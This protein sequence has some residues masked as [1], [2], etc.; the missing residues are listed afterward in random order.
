MGRGASLLYLS[1]AWRRPKFADDTKMW[2]R[3]KPTGLA[4]RSFNPTAIMQDTPREGRILWIDPTSFLLCSIPPTKIM[5]VFFKRAYVSLG[6]AIGCS[7]G[8]FHFWS[9]AVLLRLHRR[10]YSGF[11]G[12]LAFAGGLAQAP[13]P[14]W[15]KLL[16]ED[17]ARRPPHSS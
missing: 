14:V 16:P 4:R 6:Q 9:G 17:Q 1:L 5:W 3:V 15:L 12:S 2:R 7:V 11:A 10:S 8:C 13:P